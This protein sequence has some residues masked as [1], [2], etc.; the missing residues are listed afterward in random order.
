MATKTWKD[1]SPRTRR[2]LVLGASVEGLLKAAALAD[3]AR[4]PAGEVRG[5]KRWWVPAIA[6]S[7]SLGAVPVAY[8]VWGRRRG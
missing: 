1:L 3:L 4:R 2:L 6:L 5:R 8:F 7:N